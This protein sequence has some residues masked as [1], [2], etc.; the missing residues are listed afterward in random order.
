VDAERPSLTVFFPAHDEE[1]NIARAVRG[2]LDVLPRVTGD[3]EVIVVDDGSTDGTADVVEA[4]A[5]EDPR[6]RLVRHDR[7]RGYG[8]ALKT[9]IRASRGDLVFWTDGDA[10][11]DLGELPAF[12]ALRRRADAVVGYRLNR[13]E[14]PLRRLNGAA[15]SFLVGIVLGVRFRDVDCAFKVFP[16]DVVRDLPLEANGAM[17]SAELLARARRRGLRIVET[18][19]SHLPRLHGRPSGANPGVILKAFRE[20]FALS[21]KLRS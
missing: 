20:L 1:A 10:Q 14:G 8:A 19:V 21:R 15:W 9:G 16:G 4:L 3:G 6:V 17:I 11:F 18:G 5:A 2:A 7:N 13:Q 12:L